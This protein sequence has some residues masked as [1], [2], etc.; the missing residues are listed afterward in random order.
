MVDVAKCT[1]SIPSGMQITLATDTTVATIMNRLSAPARRLKTKQEIR[2]K[3]TIIAVTIITIGVKSQQHLLD[4]HSSTS[5]GLSQ[6]FPLFIIDAALRAL[7][8]SS[9]GDASIGEEAVALFPDA[10]GL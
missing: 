1:A 10:V 6:G 3:S 9:N 5:D 8:Y 4:H 2:R 7:P